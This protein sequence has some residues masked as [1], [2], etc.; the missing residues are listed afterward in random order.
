MYYQALPHIHGDLIR[1]SEQEY[2][3]WLN[4]VKSFVDL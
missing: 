1:S 4:N 2:V 3:K